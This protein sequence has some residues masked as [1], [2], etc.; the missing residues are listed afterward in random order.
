MCVTHKYF[1]TPIYRAKLDPEPLQLKSPY[2]ILGQMPL[3]LTP[4]APTSP[5][6]GAMISYLGV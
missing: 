3:S 2:R 4:G 5:S 6:L 1:F